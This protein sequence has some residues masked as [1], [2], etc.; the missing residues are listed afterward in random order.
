MRSLHKII[1]SISILLSVILQAQ[2]AELVS[3]DGQLKLSIFSENGKA[4]YSVAFSGKTVL[5]KSPLGL[6]T[7]ET[8]FSK[9][10]KLINA[11]KGKVEKK[12]TNQK[13]GE[14]FLKHEKIGC[15]DYICNSFSFLVPMGMIDHQTIPD[16]CGIIEFYHDEDNWETTFYKIRE[17]KT[18]HP[19]S[20]WKLC[21]KDHFMRT[22]AR[23]LLFKKFELKGKREELIFKSPFEIKNKK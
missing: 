10:L 4:L 2:V 1:F 14:K 9:N 12:Y 17:P 16:H 23:S 15:G 6:V 11:E 18:I 19:D 22:L 13:T 8:D 20:Y 21:D 3:P 7:N 5:E